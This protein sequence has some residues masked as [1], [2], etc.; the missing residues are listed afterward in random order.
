ML[1]SGLT[2]LLFMS[3]NAGMHKLSK[4]M[5]EPSQNS[6]RQKDGMQQYLY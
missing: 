5:W 2:S 4:K 3:F 6:S 1:W